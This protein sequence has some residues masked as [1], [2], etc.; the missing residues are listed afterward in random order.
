VIGSL[1]TLVVGSLVAL[2][3]DEGGRMKADEI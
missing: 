1:T 2:L 3:K